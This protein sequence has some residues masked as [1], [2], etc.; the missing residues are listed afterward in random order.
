MYLSQ[1]LSTSL[2]T[3][4]LILRMARVRTLLSSFRKHLV[5][6]ENYNLLLAGSLRCLD[7]IVRRSQASDNGQMKQ[8]RWE[9]S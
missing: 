5:D 8:Q 9:E 1:Y 7:A 4:L 3:A 6:F 2:S